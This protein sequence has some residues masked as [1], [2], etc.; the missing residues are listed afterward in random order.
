MYG[1]LFHHN[2]SGLELTTAEIMKA[3]IID[4]KN[5]WKLVISYEG[6]MNFVRYG[7]RKDYLSKVWFDK[8]E[9]GKD[10]TVS[11]VGI[12]GKWTLVDLKAFD[13]MTKDSEGNP[14]WNE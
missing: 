9:V 13:F 12:D 11:K 5:R 14:V 10:D 2:L 4:R 7:T 3:T 1:V 8:V 6:K